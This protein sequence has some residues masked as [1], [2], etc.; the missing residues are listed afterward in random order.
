[1]LR[2]RALYIMCSFC[3]ILKHTVDLGVQR[4]A[5][6]TID[7]PEKSDLIYSCHINS[8]QIHTN[9]VQLCNSLLCK[10]SEQSP[11]SV[12]WLDAFFNTSPVLLGKQMQKCSSFTYNDQFEVT[13][14][15]Q[16]FCEKKHGVCAFFKTCLR[17][18]KRMVL[19][20][21]RLPHIMGSSQNWNDEL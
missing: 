20:T 21:I 4:C 14:Q 19:E 18:W 11:S 7:P 12:T 2:L 15:V 5:Y 9:P 1:M 10:G 8:P 17:G 16:C 3:S 6:S 13:V